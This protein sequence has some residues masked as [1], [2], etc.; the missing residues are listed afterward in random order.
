[1]EG[2]LSLM[3]AAITG[4]WDP[5]KGTWYNF[6]KFG[7]KGLDPIDKA[8]DGDKTMW[9]VFGGATYATIRNTWLRSS[10]FRQAIWHVATGDPKTFPMKAND[11][12]DLFREVSSVNELERYI[13][14]VNTGKWLSSNETY[15]SDVSKSNALFMTLS[16]LTPQKI[17]NAYVT[18]EMLRTQTDMQKRGE[19]YA[20]RDWRRGMQ[21]DADGNHDQA[22]PFYTRA[23]NY[24]DLYGVP[25]DKRPG[26]AAQAGTAGTNLVD[27]VNWD[28][29]FKNVPPNEQPRRI[30][31]LRR[32]K[33][34][35]TK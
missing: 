31:M 3:G 8:L 15:L 14:A 32:A 13:M 24:L 11:L 34:L 27:R 22:M 5:H 7:V 26:F 19:L 9:D 33:Q 1:M 20:L 23:S 6:S 12:I 30:D 16:G 21:A 18:G 10:G 4:E 35:E 17:Q 29:A 25:L 2:G 28:W